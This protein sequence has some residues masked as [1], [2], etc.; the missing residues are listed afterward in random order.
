MAA[1]Y[2]SRQ[3]IQTIQKGGKSIVVECVD[4]MTAWIRPACF[5]TTSVP[6]ELSKSLKKT[7][8]LSSLRLP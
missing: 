2:V 8:A 3:L 1:R 7:L 4:K 6:S 5:P